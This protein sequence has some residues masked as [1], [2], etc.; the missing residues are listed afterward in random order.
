MSA[1]G[2]GIDAATTYPGIVGAPQVGGLVVGVGE[3]EKKPITLPPV[4]A[5]RGCAPGLLPLG[6]PTGVC[7]GKKKTAIRG[8]WVPPFT[9]PP[10]ADLTFPRSLLLCAPKP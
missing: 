4:P 3:Q 2:K 7:K 10:A 9:E 5:T 6:V 8:A 1:W